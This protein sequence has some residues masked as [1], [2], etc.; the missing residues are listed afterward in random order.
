MFVCERCGNRDTRYL[1]VRNN[2]YYC[3]R[4]IE[5]IGKE[6]EEISNTNN[7]SNKHELQLKYPL[8]S[9]QNIIS[10]KIIHFE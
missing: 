6:Y 9:E 3:R 10:E 5:F 4:C 2:K 8:T 1:G 7:C